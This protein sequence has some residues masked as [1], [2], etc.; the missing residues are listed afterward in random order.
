MLFLSETK[1]NQKTGEKAAKK[2]TFLG[3]FGKPREYLLK[4]T[5]KF[6]W[7]EA[8]LK[9]IKGGLKVLHS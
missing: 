2:Q 6:G 3:N 7:L 9:H 5:R 1:L 4:I 8:N